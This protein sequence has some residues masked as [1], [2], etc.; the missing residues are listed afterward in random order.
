MILVVNSC[1]NGFLKSALSWRQTKNVAAPLKSATRTSPT[2][3]G[4]GEL[5]ASAAKISAITERTIVTIS[6]IY[7]FCSQFLLFLLLTIN[8]HLGE[9]KI[10]VDRKKVYQKEFF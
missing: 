1:G 9:K 10:K 6:E 8:T 3:R 2:M 5:N 7:I 4:G